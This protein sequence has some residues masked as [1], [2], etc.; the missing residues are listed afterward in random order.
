M[1][2]SPRA[3]VTS[4]DVA[5]VGVDNNENHKVEIIADAHLGRL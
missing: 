3:P 2:T 5:R 4:I 1:R